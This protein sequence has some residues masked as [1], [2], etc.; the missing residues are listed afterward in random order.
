MKTLKLY[1]VIKYLERGTML[2]IGVL[3][4]GNYGNE[5]CELPFTHQIHS[6]PF[7]TRAK[8]ETKNG[9][10]RCFACRN[11][12]IEKAQRLKKPFGGRCI[13][14]LYE[15]VR[16]VLV[17]GDVAAIIFIGNIVRDETRADKSLLRTLEKDFSESD[18]ETVS[19]IV[20]NH[21]LMLFEKFGCGEKVS[22]KL[23]ENIK[24]YILANIEFDISI[25]RI[26]KLF[27]YNE[28][29]L[30]R[31]FRKETGMSINDYINSRRMEIAKKLLTETDRTVINISASVGFNNVTYFNRI[32]KKSEGITPS[33]YRKKASGK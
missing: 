30:G 31:L 24:S 13:N 18:C 29:Y 19:G 16:P 32:F 28:T 15:Y 8:E 14:G 6:S 3:F 2:H 5:L 23:I 17:A 10:R 21:I 33:G 22:N 26:A 11:L 7:C 1:D 4:F 27:H 20:E 12:A 9:Y 25:S